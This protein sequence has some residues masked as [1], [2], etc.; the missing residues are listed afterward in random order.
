ML[1]LLEM[2]KLSKWLPCLQLE[3]F[4]EGAQRYRSNTE[5]LSKQQGWAEGY[6]GTRCRAIASS[7]KCLKCVLP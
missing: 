7:C 4:L 2:F 5:I 6:S 3:T 1:P